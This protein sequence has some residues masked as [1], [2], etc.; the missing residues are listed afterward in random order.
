MDLRLRILTVALLA[1]GAPGF[2]LAHDVPTKLPAPTTRTEIFQ[3]DAHFC[4]M[5][6]QGS[7]PY[8]IIGLF[9]SMATAPQSEQLFRDM[10]QQQHWMSLPKDPS[11]FYTALQPVS[12][13]LPE[14]GAI[15]VLMGQDEVFAT[16]PK[17][18]DLVRYSPHFGAYEIPPSDPKARAYW[19]VDGCLAVVCRAQDKACFGRYLQGVFRRKDGMAISPETFK[20]IPHGSVIDIQSLLP[21]RD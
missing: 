5:P 14:G 9:Q 17:P 4:A 12:V 1:F 19:S 3:C 6:T 8:V 21:K 18:G 2:A 10:Q 15:A 16:T 7:Y 11:A 20:P 13:S